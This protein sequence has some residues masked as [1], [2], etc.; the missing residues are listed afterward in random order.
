MRDRTAGRRTRIAVGVA[1]AVIALAVSLPAAL[2]HK[3]KFDSNVQLKIDRSTG[4]T[5]VYSGKV[6]SEKGKCR[7]KRSIVLKVNGVVFA[8]TT[9][10]PG[11][12]WS[13]IA[14]KYPRGTDVLA[15]VKKRFLKKNDQHRHKCKSDRTTRKV[16]P[17]SGRPN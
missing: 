4:N 3:N 17:S 6:T 10:V 15:K 1:V 14:Q 8:R 2:G 12:D 16:P 7:N 5:A 9:T 13:V 11:G